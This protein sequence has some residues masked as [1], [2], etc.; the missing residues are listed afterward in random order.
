MLVFKIP[1][2]LADKYQGAGHAL[3]ASAGGQLVAL[4]Y[5]RDALPDLDIEA[6]LDGI[7]ASTVAD[8]RLAPTVRYLSSLGAVHI[9]MCSCWE[10]VEL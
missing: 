8:E 2:T 5:L 10:F 4:V 9:G 3:A 1:D 6:D 7:G